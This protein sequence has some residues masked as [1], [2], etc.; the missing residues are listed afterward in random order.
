MTKTIRILVANRPKLMRDL[1]VSILTEQ[2]DME[3]VGEVSEE[4]EEDIPRRIRETT[5][6]LIVIALQDPFRPPALC[7]TVLHQ[8]PDV[9]VIAVAEQ[10]NRC[11]CYWAVANIESRAIELSERGFLAAVRNMAE[12]IGTQSRYA[13]S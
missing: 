12:R 13:S 3:L 8:Y 4:E 9:A 6:D 10:A 2:P 11:V 5:P 1:V 7:E